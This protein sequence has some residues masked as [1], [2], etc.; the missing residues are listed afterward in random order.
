MKHFAP[1][2]YPHF[3]CIADACR[4][5]C[6][7]G[8][9]IDIDPVS[10]EK[11]GKIGGEIGRRLAREIVDADPPHFHLGAD[12]RCPFLREDGLC[13]LILELGEDSLC[14][15]CTLHPRFRNFFSDRVEIG[16]GLCCEAA[17]ELILTRG[18]EMTLVAVDE[19]GEEPF[20]LSEE[21]EALLGYR[22]E[23]LALCEDGN[24]TLEE[25]AQS[26]LNTVDAAMP[27]FTWKEWQDV[28]ACLERLDQAWEELLSRLD[29][30]SASV[31]SEWNAPLSHLFSYF[32]YRHL[33]SALDA[34]CL[35][36]AIRAR[37]CF[38]VLSVSIIRRIF[39]G[40]EQTMES[41]GEICRQY[42]AEVEYSDDNLDRILTLLGQ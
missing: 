11:Y 8:W 14:E 23:L 15:I 5:S 22:E 1:A 35:D 33:P 32:L 24:L 10:R 18:G 3:R 19:D 40:G 31:G 29:G 38:A 16:L 7:I 28:Y 13:T 4:H 41:L 42:S 39:A 26:L 2:Y 34:E 37:V 27:D 36:A 17:A 12:E 9:E 25:K 30:E 21:E 6:C 20:S